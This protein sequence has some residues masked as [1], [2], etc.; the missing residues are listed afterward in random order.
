MLYCILVTVLIYF[1]FGLNAAGKWLSLQQGRLD[2]HI[3][4]YSQV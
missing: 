2:W 4:K 3:T 1:P